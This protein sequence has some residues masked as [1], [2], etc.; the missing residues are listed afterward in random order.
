M[1][2]IEAICEEMTASDLMGDGQAVCEMRAQRVSE[3]RDA[4]K[5]LSKSPE[6][7]RQSIGVVA[8]HRFLYRHLVQDWK[9]EGSVFE[10]CRLGAEYALD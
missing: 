10:Q 3:M 7:E 8:L 9:E 2:E 5:Q 4:S 6:M 1:L